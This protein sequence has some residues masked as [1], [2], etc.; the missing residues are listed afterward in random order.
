M[1]PPDFTRSS[2]HNSLLG[3]I[4]T[5]NV[6]NSFNRITILLAGAI[7]VIVGC[8]LPGVKG[9][10]TMKTENRPIS[11]FSGLEVSG[12]YQIKWSSGKSALT[13]STDQNLLPLITTSVTGNTLRIDSKENLRPTKGI[14]INLSSASLTDV[15][16]NGA[17]SL[18]ASNLSGADLK[19]ESNGASSISVAGSVTNL[20]ATLSGA[21][22]LDAKSL[23]TQ[24]A[25]V[26]LNGASYGDVTVTETLNASISGAGGLTYSGNPKS[27][28]K[29]VAGVGRIQPRT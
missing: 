1:Q 16:L 5:A 29:S 14:T 18:T 27:V 11:D 7:A 19:L 15:K 28:E 24:T 10:G 25:K 13:I 6:S 4:H 20:E 23:Q 8:S 21:C 9:D 2:Q 26:S 12:A 3:G 22:K 17:V